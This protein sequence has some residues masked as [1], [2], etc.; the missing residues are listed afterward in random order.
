[1]TFQGNFGDTASFRINELAY[2][3]FCIIEELANKNKDYE[4]K[5]GMEYNAAENIRS[6]YRKKAK[7]IHAE[8]VK[9]TGSEIV[10]IYKD[11]KK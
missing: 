6:E 5:N 9:L 11:K 8:I 10:F 3:L 7:D 1:M 2:K 4:I